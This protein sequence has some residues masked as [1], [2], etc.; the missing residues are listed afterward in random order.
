M[1]IIEQDIEET[2][3]I[4]RVSTLVHHLLLRAEVTSTGTNAAI[5]VTY[6]TGFFPTV[7][8]KI[9]CHLANILLLH[10]SKETLYNQILQ[11]N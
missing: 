1:L 7:Y 6:I 4:S 3:I 5:S 2:P 10:S 11:I 8:F 9:L